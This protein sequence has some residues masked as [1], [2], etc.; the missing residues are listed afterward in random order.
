MG[1]TILKKALP[2]IIVLAVGVT[3]A[4]LLIL[5]KPRPR[6][7][8]PE[9]KATPVQVRKVFPTDRPVVV[10]AIGTV[11]PAREVEIV[12]QVSGRVEYV[13]PNLV[14]GG[15]VSKG[16]ALVRIDDRD[17]RAEVQRAWSKVEQA[18]SELELEKGKQ[19]VARSEWEMMNPPEAPPPRDAN[20]ALRK[21]QLAAAKARLYAA[22]A[23]YNRAKADLERTLVEAPFDAIVISEDVETGKVVGPQS[24]IATLAGIRAYWIRAALPAAEL[25]LLELP[26]EKGENGSRATVIVHRG[27]GEKHLAGGRVVRILGDMDPAGQM[28][29]LLVEVKDPLGIEHGSDK[30]T[31]PLM[32][33]AR[34]EVEIRG[35][36]LENVYAIPRKALR[37]GNRVWIM[38]G[39]GRL[40][41]KDV[42]VRR[43]GENELLVKGLAPGDRVITSAV[44]TPIP[45][46][47]LTAAGEE[48]GG[49]PPKSA[50]EPN[51]ETNPGKERAE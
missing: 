2:V 49:L 28:S 39:E 41:F 42:D 15:L 22:W 32:I 34:V 46:M 16:E 4:G 24:K 14:P 17:Y 12:P 31:V 26:D 37:E 40:R 35:K 48:K 20:L 29:R 50:A 9:E 43:R 45:G 1:N 51:G 7:R 36:T 38:D 44:A 3:A 19:D 30:S 21:P 18:R 13:N 25:A 27:G 47:K 11:V 6:L 8:P 10:E 23:E 5:S 33:N